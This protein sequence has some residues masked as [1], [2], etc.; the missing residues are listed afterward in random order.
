MLFPLCDSLIEVVF[1]V[2]LDLFLLSR[3][4]GCRIFDS[5]ILVVRIDELLCYLYN[6]MR[7]IV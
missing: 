1:D 7:E 3:R 5:M 4:D 6:S 2:F